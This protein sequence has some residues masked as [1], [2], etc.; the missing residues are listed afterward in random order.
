MLQ[1]IVEEIGN[2][3]VNQRRI[4]FDLQRPAALQA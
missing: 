3:A 1:L 2:H 4:G